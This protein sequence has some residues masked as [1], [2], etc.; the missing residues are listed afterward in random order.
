MNKTEKQEFLQKYGNGA[1]AELK[2]VK[3]DIKKLKAC[4][5][6]AELYNS[7][8][9]GGIYPVDEICIG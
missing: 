7:A 6:R 9:L 8:A 3:T 2:K 5:E 4:L 1:R